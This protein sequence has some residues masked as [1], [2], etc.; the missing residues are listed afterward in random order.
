M[1]G[2]QLTRR[3][4]ATTLHC[5]VER[6]ESLG[7]PREHSINA[8]AA[9]RGISPVRTRELVEQHSEALGA[10]RGGDLGA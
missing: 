10:D 8:V 3:E 5:A 7:I 1:H 4:I 9:D 6:F 2:S